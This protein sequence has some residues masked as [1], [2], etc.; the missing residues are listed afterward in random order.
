VGKPKRN[1]DGDYIRIGDVLRDALIED[2]KAIDWADRQAQADKIKKA[3]Q[4]A[5]PHHGGFLL[6]TSGW[7][8]GDFD[9]LRMEVDSV[10]EDE[11]HSFMSHG[12]AFGN[13][14]IGRQIRALREKI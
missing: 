3:L 11:G 13:S 6:D 7:T 8:T 2:I 4:I 12:I 9:F 10:Y 5:A 14:R 1:E